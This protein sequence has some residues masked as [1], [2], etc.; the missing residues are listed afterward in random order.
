VRAGGSFR[1]GIG[2]VNELRCGQQPQRE[3]SEQTK[4]EA[5]VNQ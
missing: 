3:K 2:G 5:Q 4:N 1:I